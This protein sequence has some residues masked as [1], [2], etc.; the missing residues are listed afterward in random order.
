MLSGRTLRKLT[1]ILQP[2]GILCVLLGFSLGCVFTITTIR[3]FTGWRLLDAGITPIGLSMSQSP[4]FIVTI[5]CPMPIFVTSV[6]P[7]VQQGYP[8]GGAGY[9]IS[10][11]GIDK[12]AHG[13]LTKKKC[14]IFAHTWTEDVRMGQCA[15]AVGVTMV[16]SLDAEGLERFHPFPAFV[17]L[18]LDENNPTNWLTHFNYHKLLVVS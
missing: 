11:M 10:R 15:Q 1:N 12:I 6:Q 2:R 16:D 3:R 9:V 13:M 8:S 5:E 17:M 4:M 7:F 18:N 14:G